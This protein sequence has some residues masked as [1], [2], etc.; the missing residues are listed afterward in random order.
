MGYV[1]RVQQYIS[2]CA[3]TILYPIWLVL[4]CYY[5]KHNC[6][7]ASVYSNFNIIY[8]QLHTHMYVLENVEHC[9]GKPEQ[10]DT[11]IL[12]LMRD[13]TSS[14]FSCSVQVDTTD[15]SLSKSTPMD[16]LIALIY[17][18]AMLYLKSDFLREFLPSRLHACGGRTSTKWAKLSWHAGVVCWTVLS[19]VTDEQWKS[20]LVFPSQSWPLWFDLWPLIS[21]Q[22]QMWQY[23]PSL[24]YL[25]ISHSPTPS[26][27][28]SH[29]YTSTP[30]PPH[31]RETHFCNTAISFCKESSFPLSAF[32]SMILTAKPLD[33]SFSCTLYT[34][35]KAPLGWEGWGDGGSSEGVREWESEGVTRGSGSR[36]KVRVWGC[37]GVGVGVGGSGSRNKVRVWGC[38]GVGVGIR[39][40]C[41]DVREWEWE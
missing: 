35:E 1:L 40:G 30:S 7:C 15:P 29:L 4:C 5:C 27:P 13:V 12:S 19:V 10:A 36:N 11:G 20:P 9:G 21:W 31:P 33:V 41:E 14:N 28:P 37:E 8:T 16:L 23:I 22:P 26:Y 34:S 32:L 38:E 3:I 39:W 18:L 6:T 2:T 25:L 24:P 17:Q